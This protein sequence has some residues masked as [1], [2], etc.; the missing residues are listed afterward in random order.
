MD[1]L[2]KKAFTL[3]EFLIVI[4]IIGILATLAMPQYQKMVQRTKWNQAMMVLDA[5]RK[6]EL[7]YYNQHGKFVGGIPGASGD[8]ATTAA[9][10][11]AWLASHDMDIVG[12]GDKAFEDFNY[13]VY[14][15]VATGALHYAMARKK[16][17]NPDYAG[18][19]YGIAIDMLT[20]EMF[21][22]DTTEYP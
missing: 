13:D 11:D 21:Y 20:G 9:E 10:L 19:K 17:K 15:P 3:V 12:V 6:A 1:P 5:I 7:F 14:V 2:K 4:V 16:P 8:M 18:S 22:G